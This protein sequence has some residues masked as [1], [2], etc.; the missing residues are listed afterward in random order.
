MQDPMTEIH[1]NERFQIHH[2]HQFLD[3]FSRLFRFQLQDLTFQSSLIVYHQ[4]NYIP[5]LG[6]SITI[7]TR[8]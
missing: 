2:A 5:F 4:C 3:C 8:T 1:F 6:T 7:M